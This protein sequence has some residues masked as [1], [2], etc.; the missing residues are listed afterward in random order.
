MGQNRTVVPGRA[1]APSIVGEVVSEAGTPLPTAVV[2]AM[3]AELDHDFS[4]VRVHADGRAGASAQA[5]G[6]RAYTVGRHIAFAP[7]QYDPTGREGRATLRHE[8]V[9]ATQQAGRAPQ[10]GTD[11]EVGPVDDHFERQADAGAHTARTD[12]A[13]LQ[14][15]PA[16]SPPPGAIGANEV[17]P[18]PAGKR[19]LVTDLLRPLV[20]GSGSLLRRFASGDA[21]DVLDI[22]L[23]P[24]TPVS[25]EGTVTQSSPELVTANV[26]LPAF[27]AKGIAARTV[28]VEL[29]ATS[30]A[31]ELELQV[32]WGTGRKVLTVK[33]Q[34][35]GKDIA[36]TTELGQTPVTGTLKATPT[37]GVVAETSEALPTTLAG[38]SPL[39]L[40]SIEPLAAKAGT[41]A[42]TQERKAVEKT[43][44]KAATPVPPRHE[45]GLSAGTRMTSLSPVASAA[46]RFTFVPVGGVGGAVSTLQ[47]DYLP[48]QAGALVGAGAA[49]EGRY[50]VAG[51]PMNASVGVDLKAGATGIG[52]GKAS[53]VLAPGFGVRVGADLGPTLR[54]FVS[55]ELFKNLLDA[56]D[57]RTGIDNVGI[58]KAGA[59]LRF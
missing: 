29:S 55:A 38:Q 43:A 42:A 31:G 22:L 56:A 3:A 1:T 49:L 34:R 5:V 14:R 21:G 26:F 7:G 36:V 44:A 11:I 39:K 25:I 30:T 19:I 45:I 10:P 59:A 46:W 35:Q 53:P 12:R 6:A 4:D 8:L 20:R 54:V 40:V 27:P 50:P 16:T 47:L 9:H 32:Q 17:M 23:D 18:F 41:E 58:V 15:Q 51:V 52:S 2:H 13:V 33:A 28:T 57:N 37:G 48:Q 24:K